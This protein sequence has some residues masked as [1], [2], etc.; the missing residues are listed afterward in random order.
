[1]DIL[2]GYLGDLTLLAVYE[3]SLRYASKVALFSLFFSPHIFLRV[4][5]REVKVQRTQGRA[6]RPEVGRST[7]PG[8]RRPSP[9]RAQRQRAAS[10]LSFGAK[11]PSK[12]MK[13]EEERGRKKK[14]PSWRAAGHAW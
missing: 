7:T 10:V 2:G 8:R 9:E 1:V 11:S 6:R 13:K 12:K 4:K 3:A 14:R 5:R